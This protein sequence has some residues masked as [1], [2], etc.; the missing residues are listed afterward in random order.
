MYKRKTEKIHK[1]IYV[2][3]ICE[4]IL[5]KKFIEIRNNLTQKNMV[6]PL[7]FELRI[8]AV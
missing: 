3:H 6:G 8:P 4:P 7:R 2:R 1:S 5:F